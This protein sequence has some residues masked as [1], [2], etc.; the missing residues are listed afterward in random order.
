MYAI[1]ETGGKQ[2][3]VQPGDIIRVERLPGE[4]GE[5]VLFD[6]VLLVADGQEVKVGQPVVEGAK[7]K[8]V[9][10]KQDRGRKVIVFKFKRRKRYHRKRGH[11]QYFTAVKIEE[12]NA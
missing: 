4:T 8:G 1:V 2:Y 9:I 12:I 11:R 10:V 5:E 6:K 7:V 3:R